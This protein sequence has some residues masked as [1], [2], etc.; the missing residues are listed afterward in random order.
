MSDA[1]ISPQALKLLL[2]SKVESRQKGARDVAA[3][4]A[5]VFEKYP[6]AEAYDIVTR[7]LREAEVSLLSVAAAT[8][9][10]GG[11]GAVRAIVGSLPERTHP[12]EVVSL[13]SS[14][15]FES[16]TDV[17]AAV[18]LAALEAAHALVRQ[19]QSQLLEVCFMQVFWGLASCVNDH[20][21]RVALLAGE[22]SLSLREVITGNESFKLQTDLFVA[23]VTEV[24]APYS[25]ATSKEQALDLPLLNW[26]FAWISHV[27]DLPGDELILLLWRFLKPLLIISGRCGGGEVTRLLQK[28]LRDTREA[29]SRHMKVQLDSLLSIAAECVE[30]AQVALTRKNALEWMFELLNFGTDELVHL[31]HRAVAASL[32]Q[33][34][35]KDLETR[36]AAQNVNHRLMQI[37]ALRQV[38]TRDVP[39][40]AVLRGVTSQLTGRGNEESRVAALEWIALV[41]HKDAAVVE[42]GFSETFET[43]LVLLCDQSAHVV[44]KAIET[45]CLISGEHKFDHFISRLVDLFHAKADVLLP[46]APTIIKQLQLRYQGEDLSQCEKLCLKLSAVLSVHEDKRFLEKVVI[47]LSTMVLTSREFLPLREIL[48][49]G[50][51]DERART[52]LVGMY[53]CWRYN[54]VAALSLCLLS[55]AYEHA[56]QLIQF[57]GSLEMSAAALL[58]LER[59]VRLIESPIFAYIRISLMEPSR[60]LPLVRTL[61]SMQLILPQGS[62][63]QSLLYRRLKV[64]PSLVTLERE[65]QAREA[66]KEESP[67]DWNRLLQLSKEAQRCV[68]DFERRLALQRLGDTGLP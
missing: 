62:P 14:M 17:D 34:G 65:S 64:I 5:A 18:R 4:T 59:L 15:V 31:I 49:R 60:C 3:K 61:F 39:Y 36:L 48:N 26:C 16:V 22:V 20:D 51:G 6:S 66:S 44:H 27:L 40:D 9:R 8:Y 21:G 13:L 42:S 7:E 55:R 43:V 25:S 58:Q 56:F 33:L 50:V 28:C 2:D 24:L 30:E 19:L 57:M 12:R 38:G 23:F 63:Q 68:S 29:F 1:F 67:I 45:L 47:T 41:L 54:T 11:L 32:S 10:R 46:K 37:V 53:P 35:S 52:T